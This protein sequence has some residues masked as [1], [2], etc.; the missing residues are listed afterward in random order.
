[1]VYDL[2]PRLGAD[3][4]NRYALFLPMFI[5]AAVFYTVYLH[6]FYYPVLPR[7]SFFIVASTDTLLNVILD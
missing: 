5:C 3:I 7:S 6:I 4:L 1:M 2:A